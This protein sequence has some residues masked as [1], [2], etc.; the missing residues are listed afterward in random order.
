MASHPSPDAIES[1]RI[2]LQKLEHAVGP[3]CDEVAFAHVRCTLLDRLAECEAELAM[4]G[5]LAPELAEFALIPGLSALMS[6]LTWSA[7]EDLQEAADK[8]PLHKLD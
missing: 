2:A 8:L 1:L 4:S 7:L 3:A 6:R 5:C